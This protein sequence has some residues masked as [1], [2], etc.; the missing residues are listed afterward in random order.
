MKK[1]KS[2]E[3]VFLPLGGSNEIGMNFNLYGFGPAHDRKWIVVDLGVTFGDQTTPGVEIILPDPS[4]IEPYAKDI[5]GIVLTHAHED[6]L[7]AVHWLWPRLKAPVYAT[8]FTAFLLRE[9]LRDA[10]ILDDVPIT[11]VPLGGRFKLGPFD[12][13]LITLTHSIPEPNGLA[14]KTPLGTILHTGD[15]KIDPEPQLGAPTDDAALRRLGDEG[16]LAMVCDST[17]VFVEGEAGSEAGVRVA[18]GNLIKSLSG[19]IAVAC[20]ASNVA[21]MDTVIRAAQACGRKVSLA[22]RSMHRMAAAARSVGLL[23]GLEPFINDD[24]AKHLPESEVLF[25]C[26][27]SQ[28]EARAAL[29]RIADGSHPHVKLGQ[30]D[31]VIFSSRVIPG[32]EIPIRNLQNKL[33]DRGVRLHTERDTPGIH[34]SGHPCREELRQMYAW[35]RPTIA[36][37]THG[38][39]RH[40]IEHAAF[41]KDLQVPHAISPRNGD[42]VRLA[43]GHPEI[44]DEVPAGR[45]Y[46]DGGVVTPENGDAL[47]ERRHAAFNGMLAVSIVL[48]GRN[49]IVSGPQVRGIGLTGDEE[50]SLDDALDDLAEEA[51]TAYK[52]LTGDTRELDEAIESAISRAVKKAAFRIW[53]RKPVVETTVLRL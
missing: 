19:K 6:H 5:I 34:V 22:G 42:M 11:E 50:Y 17:N 15:W 26:T 47:R 27:G 13:E 4:Y 35:V 21:R 36:V 44:I 24:Q 2:D 41:A 7:G 23:Q 3:L 30:G 53:E 51:E 14:I 28:G 16:V 40:L 52:K 20:F 46:V 48:D 1:S 39:R 10:G 25:L 31:H 8:P 18:L 37:P 29:S 33:A 45:L 49:K 38:E 12:L 9:K 32:N 43:P